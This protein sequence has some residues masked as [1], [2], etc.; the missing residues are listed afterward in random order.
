MTG[1]TLEPPTVSLRPMTRADFGDLLKWRL[2]PHVVRWFP[3][4]K[5]VT[6]AT[7]E[8]WYGP[9]I[10][11]AAPTRMF[12]VTADGTPVGFL[13]DYRI[14]DHP[15]FAVLTPDP[16]AI[17]IDY[18]IGDP[19]WLHR[20][21]GLRMLRAWFAIARADYPD[22]TTYFAAPDHRNVA[23]RRLLLKA[24]FVEGTWFDEAQPDGTTS[25]VVGHSLDVASVLGWLHDR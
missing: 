19:A 17:G 24:G 4:A 13:Q 12:V 5:A 20:G 16:D 21:V 1:S 3:S 22:A 8:S 14:S 18:A 6:A 10:D 11:G 7:I 15:D 23:S 9:R 25:T 2:E